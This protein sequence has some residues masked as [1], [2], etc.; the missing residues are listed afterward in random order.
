MTPVAVWVI[1]L[2]SSDTLCLNILASWHWL[3][4]RY[5]QRGPSPSGGRMKNRH[6]LVL[7]GCAAAL[8]FHV[9]GC[10]PLGSENKCHTFGLR[11]TMKN[12]GLLGRETFFDGA[13]DS[14]ILTPRSKVC[15]VLLWN[16]HTLNRR[17]KKLQLAG[18]AGRCKSP[19]AQNRRKWALMFSNLSIKLRGRNSYSLL[20]L[21]LLCFGMRILSKPD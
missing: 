18:G 6:A 7:I 9:E 21:G 14:Y 12:S 5:F 8:E 4:P 3:I 1:Y 11:N 16:V 20:I 15:L 2:G 17:G 19:Q 13:P 10:A